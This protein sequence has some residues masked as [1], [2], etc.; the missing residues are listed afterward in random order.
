MLGWGI[1]GLILIAVGL[2]VGTE[3]AG[4]AESLLSSSDRA[5]VAASG[6]TR[7]AADALDGVG[8]GIGQA[9]ASSRRAAALADDASAT[10]DA[11]AASMSLSIFG[12][13]P[14]LPLAANFTDSASEAAALSDELEAMGGSL[15]TTSGDTD[16]L[17]A[18]LRELAT[19]L[20]DSTEAAPAPPLRLALLVILVWIALP[21]V[22]AV[23]V[24]T[25]LLKGQA[26]G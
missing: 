8:T 4:R 18:E 10:L 19:V 7:Q 22:G 2:T 6:S 26:P 25:Q 14:F 17:A 20:D 12:S 5:L 23:L 11:L 16:L 3:V 15:E 1:L 9:Q 13:Q 24:G 21:A